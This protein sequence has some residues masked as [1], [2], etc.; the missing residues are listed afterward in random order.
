MSILLFLHGLTHLLN[1]LEQ[2]LQ[3]VTKCSNE[4]VLGDS[5]TQTTAERKGIGGEKA[6]RCSQEAKK[7]RL[8]PWALRLPAA[9]KDCLLSQRALATSHL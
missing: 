3:L 6:F 5:L 1:L 7:G 8:W 9:A 4:R 2:H